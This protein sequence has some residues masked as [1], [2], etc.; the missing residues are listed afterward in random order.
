MCQDD[1]ASDRGR[2]MEGREGL[3]EVIVNLYMQRRRWRK[4]DQEEMY[5]I[6]RGR[7]H[8]KWLVIAGYNYSD[9]WKSGRQILTDEHIFQVGTNAINFRYVDII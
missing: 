5:D 9:A 2:G 7:E 1:G 8:R 4:I 3:A 6:L